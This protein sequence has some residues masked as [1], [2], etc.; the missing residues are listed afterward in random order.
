[1]CKHKA[2]FVVLYNLWVLAILL[3]FDVACTWDG[4]IVTGISKVTANSIM[5]SS[6]T[7]QVPV[8]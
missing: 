8:T 1:M 3:T 5:F 4:I 7:F 2:K 6:E